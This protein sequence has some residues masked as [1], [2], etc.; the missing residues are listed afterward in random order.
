MLHFGIYVIL[1]ARD[2]RLMPH[3]IESSV[4][5]SHIVDIFAVIF[6]SLW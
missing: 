3:A 4:Q 5:S 6:I 2:Q 1:F